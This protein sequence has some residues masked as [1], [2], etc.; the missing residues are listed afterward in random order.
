MAITTTTQASHPVTTEEAT[1]LR[2]ISGDLPPTPPDSDHSDAG[3][4]DPT[5]YPLPPESDAPT[6][7]LEI[8]KKTPDSW[9]PR[10]PRLI[11]LTGVHP[12]NCEAPLTDLFN[13]GFLTSPELFYVRNHGHVPQVRDEECLNWEFSIEG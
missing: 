5:D 4:P 3:K 9:L 13:E 6:E 10:D 12:F 8:D 1:Q 7:V 11:R 2:R